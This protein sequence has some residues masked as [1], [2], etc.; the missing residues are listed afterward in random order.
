MIEVSWV[1]Y[2]L[3][4][5]TLAGMVGVPVALIWGVWWEVRKRREERK[6]QSTL[7][8]WIEACERRR[9]GR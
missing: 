3:L 5:L 8:A 6:R 2:L 7:R 4:A 9:E 1:D